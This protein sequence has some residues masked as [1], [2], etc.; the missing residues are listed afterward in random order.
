MEADLM[1]DSPISLSLFR[2][3]IQVV[4]EVRDNE[5]AEEVTRI[6]SENYEHVK[7]HQENVG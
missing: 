2:Q 6:I 3:Q 4:L 5:H 1:H 7:F